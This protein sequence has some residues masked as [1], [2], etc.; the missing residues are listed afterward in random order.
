MDP[1]RYKGLRDYL[2]KHGPFTMDDLRK[3][4]LDAALTHYEGYQQ[5]TKRAAKSI[6]IS[7]KTVYNWIKEFQMEHRI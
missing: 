7:F 5:I 3:A 1:K 6:G 4:N 2:L